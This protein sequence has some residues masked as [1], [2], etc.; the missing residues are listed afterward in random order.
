MVQSAMKNEKGSSQG[1]FSSPLSTINGSEANV[2][3]LLWL[4]VWLSSKCKVL[5][6]SEFK[7]WQLSHSIVF[8]L[9]TFPI[10]LIHFYLYAFFCTAILTNNKRHCFL[11]KNAG[12]MLNVVTYFKGYLRSC[13]LFNKVQIRHSYIRLNS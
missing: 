13:Y 8:F 3:K 7:C 6:C 1:D 11:F 12:K 5:R 2:H 4:R 10:F 9:H